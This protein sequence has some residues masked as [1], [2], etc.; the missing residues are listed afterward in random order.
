MLCSTKNERTFNPTLVWFS[1]NDA[2]VAQFGYDA[3][4]P[5]LVWFSPNINWTEIGDLIS[6]QSHLGLIFSRRY[7]GL[8]RFQN[9][10][11]SHLGL[12]FSKPNRVNFLENPETFNPTLV[13]FSQRTR[14]LFSR[15]F[16]LS[17]PPWSDFLAQGNRR[18]GRI[19]E[20]FQSHLGLIF[21]SVQEARACDSEDFQSHLGL[22][23]S[24][25]SPL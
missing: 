8:S 14:G 24:E 9:Y 12:I 17:I 15:I 20:S 3:F 11:Q 1:L 7:S 22:I 19:S 16:K 13:W 23:F 21:S 2:V 6:F 10:F 18:T 4:N 5:T 25:P